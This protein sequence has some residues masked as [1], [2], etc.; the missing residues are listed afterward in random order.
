MSTYFCSLSSVL[1]FSIL[2]GYNNC[3]LPGY[4]LV[5]GTLLTGSVTRAVGRAS[6]MLRE[7]YHHH[8][9]T[10][11]HYSRPPAPA[12]CSWRR[13]L[14]LAAD[15]SILT[16]FR[17]LISE[18][19]W[20]IVAKLCH[21]FDGDPY[22]WNSVRNLGAQKMKFRR[23]FGQLRNLN[24]LYELSHCWL[25]VPRTKTEFGSRELSLLPCPKY[26]MTYPF[27]SDTHHH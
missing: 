14:C 5:L 15:V 2:T 9:L 10:D 19:A 7:T 6:S 13:P 4:L 23:D 22:L 3:R 21:V 17:R 16:F 12:S 1:F 8:S 11:H 24:G 18:V 25:E 26:G 20:P 27:L